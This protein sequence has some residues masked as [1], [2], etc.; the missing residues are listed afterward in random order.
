[1]DFKKQ[2]GIYEQIAERILFDILLGILNEGDRISSVRDMAQELQV[3]P[4]TVMRAY[5]YLNDEDIIQT[6]RGVGYFITDNAKS[7][8]RKILKQEFF[9]NQLPDVLNIMKILEIGKEEI[10]DKL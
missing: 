4:N 10:L 9:E 6:Q 7:T 1:M 8:A 5:T 2:K 3:N